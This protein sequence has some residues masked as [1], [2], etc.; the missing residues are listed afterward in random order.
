[1]KLQI[2]KY[3]RFK[4]LVIDNDRLFV[5]DRTQKLYVEF[6]TINIDDNI[7]FMKLDNGFLYS[8]KIGKYNVWSN[9]QTNYIIDFKF[10]QLYI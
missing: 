10:N 3:L 2:Q 9:S 6:M 1:M 7:I 5:H 4:T 8:N